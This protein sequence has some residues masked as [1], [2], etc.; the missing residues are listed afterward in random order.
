LAR[1]AIGKKERL[2]MKMIPDNLWEEIKSLIPEKKS[3]YGRPQKCSRKV[4]DAVFYVMKTGIQWHYIP[5][6]FG[7]PSTIH[8]RFRKWVKLGIFQKI[9]LTA[10]E[11]YENVLGVAGI[12]YA[13]DTSSSKAPL[14][15]GWSGKNPTD[16]AKK[17]I[18]KSLI[19]D[20]R[21][22]PLVITVGAANVHDSKFFEQTLHESDFYDEHKLKIMAADS[23]YDSKKIKKTCM[24][25]NFI[26]LASTNKRR[27]KKKIVFKP[28]HRWI[29]ERTIGWLHWNRGIKT[30]WAKSL[31]SYLAFCCLACSIQLFKMAGVFV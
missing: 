23:A 30:C 6:S 28:L 12:W 20:R 24:E 31:E 27:D 7:K 13:T 5:E 29:V 14:A 11:Y 16:R 15:V 26:L 1:I 9:M 4:L 17:G 18:K 10:R 3:K 21:G 22:A 19:T 2:S 25:S 8:G